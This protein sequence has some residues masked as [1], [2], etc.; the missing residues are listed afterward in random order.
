LRA[1]ALRLTPDQA[2]R[3]LRSVR[4]RGV[5]GPFVPHDP[6][7][8][9][10]A[11]VRQAAFLLLD[12][13]LE[14]FYGGA[15]GGGKSDA[16]L[17]AALQYVDVPG[18]AAIL[19]RRTYTDLELPGGL[20]PRSHDWLGGTEARFNDRSH[21]WTF[22][23]GAT[24]SFGYLASALDKYRY[25]SAEFQFVGFDELTQFDEASYRYLFSRM[26][27]P[28]TGPLSRVPLRMRGASNPGD[29]GHAW[30][31][32]RFLPKVVADPLTGVESTIV[33]R[34]PDSH[35]VR[36]FV[37][38]RLS[39]NPH[40]D[41][42]AYMDNL[43]R[44]DPLEAARLADGDWDATELGKLFGVGKARFLE[45]RPSDVPKWARF[46]DFAATEAED[47][48]DPDYTVGSLVGRRPDASIVVADIVRG[49]W[50]PAVVEK[51]V[52]ETAERDG[53]ATVIRL[54]KEPGSAG[55]ANVSHFVRRVLLGFDVK[56]EPA[57]GAKEVRARALAAQ[58][59]AENVYLVRGPWNAAF[60]EELHA[61]P[62]K[63]VH[64]DQ[65][66]ATVGAFEVVAS[67]RRRL[68]ALGGS[69]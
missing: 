32:D 49:R 6:L 60:V 16:L 57:T 8:P 44:L 11:N 68:R 7:E 2:T 43:R 62:S 65:V 3:A 69:A 24:V 38:A 25:K 19:F 39:D 14:V 36:V 23:S 42:E 51:V 1:R 10:K 58:W 66:D 50:S 64:D 9:G 41:R 45:A 17:M 5:P 55:K 12:D 63:G 59:D 35:Q 28:S 56:G 13:L 53:I 30:V 46:W 18:Y 31:K 29:V 54:E 27:R 61:F 21:T 52:R 22:P 47:G 33:P 15:A 67:Y 34:D 48:G 26:R 40:L 4:I 37:P 20:L